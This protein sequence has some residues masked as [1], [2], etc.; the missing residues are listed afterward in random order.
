LRYTRAT[1]N[2]ILDAL[3]NAP[4][5]DLYEL[6]LALNRMLSDPKRILEVR[7]HLSLGS[8]V[9]YFDHRCNALMPGRVVELLPTSVTIDDAKTP[10]RW[11]LPY[12]AIVV[13]TSQHAQMPPPSRPRPVDR[14]E[15]A[16]GDT[17][18]FTDKHL[19]ERI[20]TIV[21]MNTKTCSLDCDGE[22]RQ[23][24]CAK[25]SIYRLHAACVDAPESQ[26]SIT[27]LASRLPLIVK[28]LRFM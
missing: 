23:R 25:L 26:K 21:R 9:L 11:K 5:I 1:D 10:S 20:G 22:C 16:V 24:C 17:V 12:A 13:D 6:N 8:Q 19:R 18:G 28:L 14:A 15:F 2:R 7:R 27:V 3:R 4:S